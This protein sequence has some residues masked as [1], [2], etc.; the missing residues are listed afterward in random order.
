[1]ATEGFA[2]APNDWAEGTA[3]RAD[4]ASRDYYNRAALLKWQNFMG[5]W[6]DS[7][8]VPQGE[9]PYAALTLT[10]QD[11]ERDAAW[12]VTKL[13]EEWQDGKYQNQGFLLRIIKGRGPCHFRSREFGDPQKR[14][15]L[16][17][18][19]GKGDIVLACRADTFLDT[20]TY[21]SLGDGETL[22][23]S[24]RSSNMLVRFDVGQVPADAKITSAVLQLCTFKQYGGG[25]TIGVFRCAQGYRKKAGAAIPGLSEKY[26]EDRGIQEDPDV[27]FSSDFEPSQW[28]ERW[29]SATGNLKQVA[30]EESGRFEPWQG[31]A[32]RAKIAKGSHHAM[33]LVYK[34]KQETGDEPEAI[35]FRYYLRLAE[36]WNQTIQGGKMPGISGT[37]GIAG[38]GGR[39][40]DGTNGWS[41]RGA[42]HRTIPDG[43]PLAGRHP[44]GTYCY[45]GDQPGRYGEVWLWQKDYLGYLEKNRWYC[46]EQFVKLNTPG[47]KDG[48]LKAWIDGRPAFEKTDIRF[49]KV[50]RL[51]IEQ[52]WMNVYHGGKTASPHDQHLYI[53]NVVVAR[54]YIGP[55]KRAGKSR[56]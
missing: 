13:V 10:V 24:A 4:G 49:R 56:K 20:S 52:I 54:K 50:K 17:V 9:T 3:G 15:R 34:F 27:I 55:M 42:F 35:Y 44:I 43:N 33:S 37:Y 45:H 39:K 46:V 51:K 11:G 28:A 25:G 26:L 22:K 21:R 5:D 31:K 36:D 53:D 8:N 2:A 14:P 19:T 12:D 38:W 32:V 6:R 48:V 16:H 40:S 30:A 47:V 29:T 41:T 1:M 7:R 18:K 23:V